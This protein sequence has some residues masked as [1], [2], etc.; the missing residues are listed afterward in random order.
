VRSALGRGFRSVVP[1]D[2]HT[3]SDRPHL[4]A[5]KIIEHHNAVWADFMA[6][7]GPALVLPSAELRF[8]R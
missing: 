3:T 6:P 8:A 2:G 5:A 1:G 7:A 4:P